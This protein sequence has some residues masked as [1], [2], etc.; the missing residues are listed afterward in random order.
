MLAIKQYKMGTP[1][2]MVKIYLIGIAVKPNNV[3]SGV[4]GTAIAIRLNNS[5][6]AYTLYDALL[7]IKGILAVL[8]ICNPTKLETT[9]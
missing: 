7:W 8:I 2:I 5:D 6:V 1:I 4:N 3:P 9:P